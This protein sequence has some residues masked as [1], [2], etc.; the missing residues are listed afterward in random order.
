MEDKGVALV[1]DEF[2]GT[3]GMITIKDVTEE[4]VGE[5]EDE[6]DVDQQ[7]IEKI[8]DNE[9]LILPELIFFVK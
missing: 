9:Y 7:L 8:S 4:I 1:V 3:S 6:Y 2:G 5:I